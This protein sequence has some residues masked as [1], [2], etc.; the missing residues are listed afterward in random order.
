GTATCPAVTSSTTMVCTYTVGSTHNSARLDY[1]STSSL[2]GTIKDAS[3]NASLRTLPAVGTSGLY[4]ANITVDTTA[5][6]VTSVAFTSINGTAVISSPSDLLKLGDTAVITVTF[7]DVVIVSTA[8]GTPTLTLETGSTDTEATYAGGSGSSAL[9]FTYT[10]ATGDSAT[11]LNYVDANSLTLNGGSITDA[12]GNAAIL[13]L[14]STLADLASN[15]AISVDGILP[16]VTSITRLD[17]SSRNSL[18]TTARF[19][20]TFSED[21]IGVGTA[22]FAV[23]TT[24]ITG[25]P[26]VSG[27]SGSGSAYTVTVS[28]TGISASNG[29]LGLGLA[30]DVSI[31]DTAGNAL[32][33]RTASTSETYAVDT[34]APT[35]SAVTFK[36]GSASGPFKSGTSVTMSVTSGES[37]SVA[38]VVTFS[39]A[40]TPTVTLNGSG[41]SW[42][43]TVANLTGNGAVTYTMVLTDVAGNVTT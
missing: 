40:G 35:A 20:A 24:G 29:T 11:D 31:T 26:T 39:G 6:S 30:T 9:T 1:S 2:T 27:I 15:A 22:D 42:T 23:S 14:P 33:V 18:T 4:G 41:T 5:P 36:N 43:G 7:D 3:G 34:S 38:P 37:L 19:L 8:S 21:V 12:A 16:T 28:L 17:G 10:V 25:T 32:T 13:T